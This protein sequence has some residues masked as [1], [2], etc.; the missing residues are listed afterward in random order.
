MIVLIQFICCVICAI[1]ASYYHNNRNFSYI[2]IEYAPEIMGVF[3]YF[4]YLLLLNTMIP[5]SLIVSLEFV[6]LFQ[7]YFMTQD[8]DLKRN[9]H[10]LK[11]NTSTIL[12]DLG[13]I[14][15]IFSDKTGTLTKNEMEYKFC[16]IGD[17]TYG[18]NE[19]P[20]GILP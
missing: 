16:C 2:E 4:S 5:I 9:N 11:C 6:K 8:D 3:G 18:C 15:Y 13:S 17:N 20:E 7:S 12:E 19:L 10:D 1:S 14:E